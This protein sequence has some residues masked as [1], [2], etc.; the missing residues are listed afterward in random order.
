M[1]RLGL[2]L[3]TF[4][5]LTACERRSYVPDAGAHEHDGGSTS[6]DGG[7]DLG[8][9]AGPLPS[10]GSEPTVPAEVVRAG[11]G[12][13]LLR[14]TVL[15]PDKVIE[16]GEVLVVGN[17]IACV[18]ADC[19]GRP[20]AE[21]VTVIETHGL[22]SPGLIDSHN[23]IAYNFLAEWEPGVLFDS[24]DQWRSNADYRAWVAPQGDLTA[25]GGTWG[26]LRSIIH[27]TTTIQG[28]SV[29]RT[30]HDRLARNADHYHGLAT[31]PGEAGQ[32]NL[33]TQIASPA[34]V[35]TS[36]AEGFAASFS[37]ESGPARRM[38]IH[39]CEGLRGSNMEIEFD[40]WAGR[41]PRS[42]DRH[43]GLSLLAYDGDF[44]GTNYGYFGVSVLIHSVILTDEQIMETIDTGSY[45]VWSP[46]SNMALYGATAPIARMLEMG[47]TLGLGPD[48]TPS[49]EDDMLSE[50]RFAY[51]YGLREGIE[52]L[53][54]ARLWQ[55]ATYDGA[56]VVGL[57]KWIGRLEEGMRA[58][59]AVFGRRSEDP[60]RAVIDSR[61]EDVRL[62]MIDGV[63]YYGDLA[64]EGDT[65]ING[66]CD[67]IDACGAM[68]YLC[69]QNVPRSNG[70][71]STLANET[72]EDVRAQLEEVL[73]PLGRLGDLQELIVCE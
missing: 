30:A 22:I 34:D 67:V 1:H 44:M 21:T 48:W 66:D 24:R 20:E 68:K 60:Y 23:H 50:M 38:A 47:V 46:S 16:R 26:E 59:I 56:E 5:F 71:T 64:L 17:T 25:P 62:V 57:E 54:P 72:V 14:G 55:M 43:Q 70:A 15:A 73:A 39:M 65:A 29:K 33:R 36:T 10:D 45:V 69:L 8:D 27:G 61:A 53:D 13:F 49:G 19:S 35:T 37:D 12:G 18:A 4:V 52:L 2:T 58:D 41:D 31:G 51:Q 32:G 11:S 6:D 7:P 3:L 42:L 63:G 28:Q 9:D 40:S